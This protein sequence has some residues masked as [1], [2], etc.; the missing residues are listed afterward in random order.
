MER[1]VEMETFSPSRKRHDDVIPEM[2]RRPAAEPGANVPSAKSRHVG[3]DES[4]AV[5]LAAAPMPQ[6]LRSPEANTMQLYQTFVDLYLPKVY[7]DAALRSILTAAP[8]SPALSSGLRSVS[9]FVAHRESEDLRL[10]HAARPEY[11]NALRDTRIE[12]S[13]LDKNK[14]A[15]VG[16]SHM[17]SLCELFN[18]L[19]LSE[20]AAGVYHAR[21]MVA[22]IESYRTD[23]LTLEIRRL[24]ESG[25]RWF[26]TWGVLLARRSIRGFN[27]GS[28]DNTEEGG[29]SIVIRIGDLLIA[30]AGILEE[31][32]NLC[33]EYDPSVFRILTTLDKIVRLEGTLHEWFSRYYKAAPTSGAMY[34]TV[35]AGSLTRRKTEVWASP[36]FKRIYDFPSIQT[37]SSHISYWMCQMLLVEARI[38][39]VSTFFTTVEDA[40]DT[41]SADLVRLRR[42]ADGYADS[43]C[44]SMPFMG[45][46]DN[47]WAGRIMAIRP[48]NLLMMHYKQRCDWQ[49][50]SWCAQCASDLKLQ[51]FK[52]SSVQ[53][54]VD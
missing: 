15:I 2:L 24:L 14:S 39:I 40:I 31:S 17:L 44:M 6:T 16:M 37:A 10:F 19:S 25:I 41:R 35:P 49:K 53:K 42:L 9:L 11:T 33:K 20:G 51:G 5:V 34:W 18:D 30:T 38:S 8:A 36:L 23:H 12:L 13:R 4:L 26:A 45:K 1:I 52:S 48:L 22:F 54:A 32:D 29:D 27:M 7:T 46:S 43:I 50:L 21:W 47:G 3:Q 28:L